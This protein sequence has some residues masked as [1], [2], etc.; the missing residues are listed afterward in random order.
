VVVLPD[1]AWLTEER[2]GVSVEEDIMKHKSTNHY[3][4]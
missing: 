3:K 2:I 1:F 4:K